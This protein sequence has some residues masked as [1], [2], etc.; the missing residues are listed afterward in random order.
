MVWINRQIG[1]VLTVDALTIFDLMTGADN[2]MKFDTTI[3]RVVIP[4][5]RFSITTDAT[6]A[7]RHCR[8]ALTT[9]RDTLD[10]L[11]FQSLFVDSTGPP[12]L[13]VTGTA[14][15]SEGVSVNTLTLDST[16]GRPQEIK[17]ARRFKE[18]DSTLWLVVENRAEAGDTALR[19]DGFIR[20]LVRIP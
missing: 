20:T 18:N 2:F 1:S 12:W 10:V 9:G 13:Y 5:L 11:D 4:T 15:A 3:V 8:I 14:F 7:V 17:S 16:L 6:A 19:I